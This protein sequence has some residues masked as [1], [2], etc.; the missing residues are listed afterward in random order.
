MLKKSATLAILSIAII[1]AVSLGFSYDRFSSDD[2]K[3]LQ[4]FPLSNLRPVKI[5][6]PIVDPCV[7]LEVGITPDMVTWG[8]DVELSM[9]AENC[10][11]EALKIDIIY[12]VSTDSIVVLMAKT[13][14]L[15][16][17]QGIIDITHTRAIPD[18]TPAGEYDVLVE[19][20]VDGNVVTTDTANITIY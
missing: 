15:L 3:A 7:N 6:P 5:N 2:K 12:T 20:I 14:L 10:S 13:T 18:G 4:K 1:L 8:D 9:M 17:S 11:E 19:A 16:A